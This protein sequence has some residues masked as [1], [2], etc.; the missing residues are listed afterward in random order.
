MTIATININVLP[1]A[2]I[3][4]RRAIILD[5]ESCPLC[6]GPLTFQHIHSADHLQRPTVEERSHCAVCACTIHENDH[7]LQ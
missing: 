1:Q 4:R 2:E 7:L 5:L 3:E 6:A